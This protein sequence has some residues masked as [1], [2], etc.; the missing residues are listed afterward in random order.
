M[1]LKLP[2][3]RTILPVLE[4]AKR[5]YLLWLPIKRNMPREERFGIGEKIDGLLL[6]TLDG[7]RVATFAKGDAKRSALATVSL[8]IDGLKFFTQL[9]WEAKLVARTQYAELAGTIEEVG[10]MVGGWRKGLES[11]PRAP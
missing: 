4:R 5:A 11:K 9:A 2:P 1:A 8:R 10:R 3:P 6:E 7:L